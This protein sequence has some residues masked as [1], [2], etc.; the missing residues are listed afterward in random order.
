MS[1]TTAQCISCPNQQLLVY[2]A[3][4]VMQAAWCNLYKLFANHT[5]WKWKLEEKHDL[6]PELMAYALTWSFNHA[7]HH[8]GHDSSSPIAVY[9]VTGGPQCCDHL[10]SVPEG[11]VWWCTQRA[12]SLCMCMSPRVKD[13]RRCTVPVSTCVAIS[14]MQAGVT[15]TSF[16]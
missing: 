9:T 3:A 7:S 4:N 16:C 13:R 2:I 5:A 1:T 10:G 14:A 12:A 6:A 8:W 15:C 11:S